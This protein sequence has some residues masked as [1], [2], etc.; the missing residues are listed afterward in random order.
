M[1]WEAVYYK[2]DDKTSNTEE[3]KGRW[4]GVSHHACDLLTYLIYFPDTHKN[5]SRSAIRKADPNKGAIIN[6]RLDQDS[7]D[8]TV[9]SPM[10]FDILPTIPDLGEIVEN[11]T[12]PILR[13]SLR[14]HKRTPDPKKEK[15]RNYNKQKI[16]PILHQ[17]VNNNQATSTLH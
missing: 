8:V 1:F 10:E 14:R 3:H 12:K 9:I 15:K 7:S 17:N 4:V 6:K 5:V 13:R 11:I 2:V 16:S